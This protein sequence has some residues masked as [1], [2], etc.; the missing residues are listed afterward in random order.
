MENMSH[1]G[2]Y[3]PDPNKFNKK[4]NMHIEKK[5]LKKMPDQPEK[6][7]TTDLGTS[8]KFDPVNHCAAAA[9]DTKASR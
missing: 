6:K 9:I 4:R 3:I 2:T 1:R 7:H 8:H 5:H